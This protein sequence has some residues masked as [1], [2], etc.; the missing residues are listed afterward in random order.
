MNTLPRAI[1]K[2]G[3]IWGL[4]AVGAIQG[5]LITWMLPEQSL[6]FRTPPQSVR[7]VEGR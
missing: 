3:F 1:K 6:D 7:A 4:V 2:T 5:L